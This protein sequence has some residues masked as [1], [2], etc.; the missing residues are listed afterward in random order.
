VSDGIQFRKFVSILFSLSKASSA[1]ANW[2]AHADVGPSRMRTW[3][4]RKGAPCA[5]GFFLCMHKKVPS[6]RGTRKSRP[7]SIQTAAEEG[8]WVT[9]TAV[10]TQRPQQCVLAIMVAE[11]FNCKV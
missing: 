10:P 9:A 5:V 7:K 11:I 4:W 8:Y 1:N 2:L 3:D 6:P